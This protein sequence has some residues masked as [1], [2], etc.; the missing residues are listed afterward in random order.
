MKRWELFVETFKSQY[1]RA[2]TSLDPI[3]SLIY[4]DVDFE[5][6]GNWLTREEEELLKLLGA[7]NVFY[8]R[9]QQQWGDIISPSKDKLN[10]A[11]CG[12][13]TFF[14]EEDYEENDNFLPIPDPE[15]ILVIG[16]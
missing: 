12:V 1:V 2:Y 10:H 8:E 9:Q 6:R 14:F 4:V 13:G 7:V 16:R 5:K 3:I 11:C 15:L